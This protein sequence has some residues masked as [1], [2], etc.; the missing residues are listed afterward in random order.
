MMAERF[1]ISVLD[2]ARSPWRGSREDS[3]R[4]AIALELASWDAERREWYLAVP[5]EMHSSGRTNRI[6]RGDGSE[7]GGLDGQ[8]PR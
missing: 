4:D 3:M 7:Q 1:R 6:D 2:R 5:V 8:L